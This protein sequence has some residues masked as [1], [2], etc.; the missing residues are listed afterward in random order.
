MGQ[1]P[2]EDEAR[3]EDMRSIPV[4]FLGPFPLSYVAV[5]SL[6]S[7]AYE[8]VALFVAFHIS[9]AASHEGHGTEG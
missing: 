5:L 9:R 6:V 7:S 2:G 1:R 4:R 3:C 8:S